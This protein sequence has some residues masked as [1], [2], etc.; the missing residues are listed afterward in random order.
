MRLPR[1]S[2]LRLARREPALSLAMMSDL[3]H[4]SADSSSRMLERCK[5]VQRFQNHELSTHFYAVL[6]PAAVR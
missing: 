2:V 5:P 1:V 6:Q 4:D 3:W